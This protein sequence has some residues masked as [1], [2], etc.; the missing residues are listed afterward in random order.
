MAAYILLGAAIGA[1]VGNLIPPGGLFWFVVGGVSGY[2]INH[3]S[4]RRF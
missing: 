2:F 4:S 3:Y 1:I